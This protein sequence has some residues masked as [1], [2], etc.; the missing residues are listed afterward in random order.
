MSYLVVCWTFLWELMVVDLTRKYQWHVGANPV[1]TD[2]V[3]YPFYMRAGDVHDEKGIV[4]PTLVSRNIWNCHANTQATIC[5][6]TLSWQK[7]QTGGSQGMI[8]AKRLPT[9]N[10]LYRWVKPLSAMDG[11]FKINIQWYCKRNMSENAQYQVIPCT[12]IRA[13]AGVITLFYRHIDS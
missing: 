10:S 4:I 2:I 5:R 6:C 9:L 3:R 12:P 11:S 8:H 7:V 1:L 13:G